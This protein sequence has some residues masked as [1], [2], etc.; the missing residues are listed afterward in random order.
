MKN[1][2]KMFVLTE[3]VLAV[4]VIMVGIAMLRG[5]NG[6]ERDKISVIIQNSDDSQWAA[7]KYGLRMAAQDQEMEMFV[8]STGTTM[9]AKEE[10]EAIE[11]EIENGADA[12]IVQPVLT[13]DMENMLKKTVKKIP[14]MLVESSADG[15]FE[16]LGIPAVQPDNYELGKALAEELLK[17]YN[18]K[19]GRK[20][21][22]IVSEFKDSKALERQ[23]G[24]S[25]V[26]KE[27]GIEV[28]WTVSDISSE[29][30]EFILE[31]KSKVD[32]VIA[33][34]DYSLVMAGK[35]ALSNNLHGALVYGI[36]NSMDAVYCLDTGCVQ[37][38]VVPDDFSMGYQSLT[39]LGENLGHIFRKPKSQTVS[40]TIMR[41]DTL[42]TEENQKILFTM[43]Q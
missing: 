20:T 10:Q 27:Q 9:S 41:K 1:S 15:E 34:D 40:Y 16:K 14:V 4:M 22:G 21:I 2:R 19:I 32:F 39:E 43:S 35:A 13:G 42:F 33:L 31:M 12:V 28:N 26:L 37:C 8:V 30:E 3:A 11:R 18:G 38:L 23:E 25:S 29:E 6:E 17:D 36:G 7:F 5:K 24:L